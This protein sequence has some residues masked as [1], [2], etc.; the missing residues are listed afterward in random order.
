MELKEPFKWKELVSRKQEFQHILRV[1]NNYYEMVA[2]A[3]S[4]SRD[5]RKKLAEEP[6]AEGF[7]VFFK[8]FGKYEFEVLAFLEREP[9]E[10]ERWFHLDGIQEE[11]DKLLELKKDNHPVFQIICVEDLYQMDSKE[12]LLTDIPFLEQKKDEAILLD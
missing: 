3:K 2:K 6:N 7:R 4:A 5:F 11:R 9:R 10:E 1:L 12:V 8:K